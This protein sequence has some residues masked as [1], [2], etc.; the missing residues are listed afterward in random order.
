MNELPGDG[1]YR[2]NSVYLASDVYD[3][4]KES[5]KRIVELIREDYAGEPISL[6]D[7][8]C[9]SG[10]F[11]HHALSQLNVENCA[12]VDISPKHLEVAR[13]RLPDV[14]FIEDSILQ[15][16]AGQAQCF[17]VCTCIGT[18][19]VFDDPEIPLRSLL[20]LVK[21]T[22]VLYIHVLMNE[23]PVDVVMRYRVATEPDSS[24]WRP[25]FNMF[26]V[27]TYRRIAK[28]IDDDLEVEVH[29]FEMPFAIAKREDC[30]RAWTITTEQRQH[31]LTVGTGQLLNYKM[32]RVFY[33]GTRSTPGQGRFG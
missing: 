7:V 28:T 25:A 5:F 19:H 17:D 8:G 4:P 24:D 18:M 2:D 9:A 30:M 23:Y 20:N 11:I 29:S 6:I 15:P 33:R 10:A 14:E 26:S 32:L 21:P 16:I 31:Q 13:K 27:E 1:G 12:G 3:E 22:G